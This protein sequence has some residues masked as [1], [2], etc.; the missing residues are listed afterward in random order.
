MAARE[1]TRNSSSACSIE[2]IHHEKRSAFQTR[3]SAFANSV[4]PGGGFLVVVFAQR[5]RQIMH[6]AGG[7]VEPLAPVG[8]TMWAAS[9][10]RNIRPNRIG[11]ATKLRSGA[12]LFSID[13]PVTRLS[14]PPDPAALQFVPEP[15][16]RPLIDVI[17]ERALQ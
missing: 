14:R 13:G 4:D 8:G 6:V 10:A 1:D 17:V 5:L 3:A 15:L 11:S 2:V 16:V 12:M 7:E 9:P